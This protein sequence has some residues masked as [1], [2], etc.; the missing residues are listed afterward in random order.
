MKAILGLLC[1]L[2]TVAPAQELAQVGAAAPGPLAVLE[3]DD[4]G[5]AIYKKGY[6]AILAKKWDEARKQFMSLVKTYPTSKYVDAAEYWTAYS[7]AQ[8]DQEKAVDLYQRFIE[9][10]SESQYFNDAVADYEKLTLRDK[11]A[12]VLAPMP[13]PAPKAAAGMPVG[14]ARPVPSPAPAVWVAPARS[15]GKKGIDPAVQLKMDAIHALGSNPEDPQAY[16]TVKAIAL[17]QKQPLEL[18][19][20]ALHTVVR[21]KDHDPVEVLLGVAA[22]GEVQLRTAAIYG[23]GNS[24][25]K[26]DDRAVKALR[27]YALDG[28]QAR[29]IREASLVA[30]FRIDEAGMFETLT[31]IARSDPDRS[32][33]VQAVYMIGQ[34][35]QENPAEALKILKA[36]ASDESQDPELREAAV[37]ALSLFRSEESLA[38]LKGIATGSGE[39]K[40]RLSAIYAM[41]RYQED[42]PAE[43]EQ[44]LRAIV[45][46]PRE[47]SEMRLSA[48]YALRT[49]GGAGLTDF[50]K[51]LALN[52]EDEQIRQ[53]SLHVL[54]QS[55]S[56]KAALLSTFIELFEKAPEGDRTLRET[57]LYGIGNV[58]N[59]QAVA[60]LAT[61]AKTHPDYELR[62]RAVYYLG[63]IGGEK[64]KAALLEILK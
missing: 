15:S 29:E 34:H 11:G 46:N 44:T 63:S 7:Y 14:V 28:K 59:D 35:G 45:S 5:Q 4:P 36:L 20:T 31:S 54:I 50:Y 6:S 62:R 12:P 48:L 16:E 24:A 60:Y 10:Y 23:I 39:K 57:A 51:S 9:Q 38:L 32:L 30:L 53:A 49:S 22:S 41:S 33:R 26:G 2:A 52:D 37:Q 19:E 13:P 56:D 25:D 8:T 58:G 17:D 42:P 55:S 21:F 1:I 18:R 3:Q 40:L 27:A 64:A 47:D 61:V 43:V